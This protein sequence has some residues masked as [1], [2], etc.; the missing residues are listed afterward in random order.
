MKAK[1]LVALVMSAAMVVGAASLFAACDKDKD[2][3]KEKPKPT[4]IVP[5]PP[6]TTFQEDT[7]TYYAVGNSEGEGTLKANG[8]A[9]DNAN[10]PFTKD[11]TVTDANVFTLELTMYAGDAFKVLFD[12]EK[13][14]GGTS[15]HYQ[16]LQGDYQT[17]FST[18]DDNNIICKQGQDGVYLFTLTTDLSKTDWH[19]QYVLTV[20]QTDKIQVAYD[21]EVTGDVAPKA[22]KNN[23]GVWT[24][25][26]EIKSQHLTCDE[27]GAEVAE[28]AQYAVVYV[29]NNGVGKTDGEALNICDLNYKKAGVTIEGETINVNLLEVGK[30]TVTFKEED[31]SVT[32]N[33]I[34]DMW[35]F[36]LGSATGSEL[37]YSGETGLWSGTLNLTAETVVK[38]TNTG[39]DSA[40]DV[41]V[42]T[43]AAGKWVIQYNPT[44]NVVKSAKY[45]WYVIGEYNGW[46]INETNGSVELVEG[47]NNVWTAEVTFPE[48]QLGYKFVLGNVLAGPDWSNEY[49][50]GTNISGDAAIPA[51]GTY[52][53][54]WN[55]T[56]NEVTA[57]LKPATPEV[58]E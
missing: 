14:W 29:H 17:Y 25:D 11:T 28:G 3:D 19:E 46:T 50:S 4:P 24:V 16:S 32:I 5:G 47:E 22:M 20:E 48:G 36:V 30:Y 27:N 44:N 37:T 39:D 38:L 35:N 7:N 56:T 34:T 52:I 23:N 58:T 54:T 42:G 45:V 49:P 21:M 33:K 10:I 2:K 8:W 57:T 41:T 53:I 13:G 6:E 1:K 18:N 55:K 40:E 26:L 43:L 9:T 51:A 31:G 15:I 12:T